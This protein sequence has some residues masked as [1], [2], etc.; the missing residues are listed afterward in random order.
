MFFLKGRVILNE[1]E[2]A[3]LCLGFRKWA[4][5]S[6]ILD[7]E[8]ASDGGLL[9]HLPALVEKSSAAILA[10]GYLSRRDLHEVQGVHCPG[11]A[12]N[13]RATG[14]AAA[15]LHSR[16]NNPDLPMSLNN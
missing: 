8:K 10:V 3:N 2:G 13:M 11:A 7:M 4:A 6:I 16:A 12:F 9:F 14:T 15:Q 1:D 5:Q